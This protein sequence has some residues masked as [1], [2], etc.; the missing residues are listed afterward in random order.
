M[1]GLI[2]FTEKDWTVLFF[3]TVDGEPR[4]GSGEGG[5]YALDDNRLV[6][7]HLYHLSAGQAVGS[8]SESPF[9]MQ[10]K[11]LRSAVTEP[12]EVE[13]SGD[14]LTIRFPSGNWMTFRRSSRF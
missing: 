2:F 10:V 4:R 6:F 11:D 14:R 12:C 1:D 5:V 3:V 8:L 9:R 7:T 13:L